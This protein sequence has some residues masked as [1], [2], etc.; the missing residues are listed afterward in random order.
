MNP[1]EIDV[2]SRRNVI[3]KIGA[4]LRSAGWVIQSA[5]NTDF[6]SLLGIAVRSFPLSRGQGNVGYL[7]VV[8]R[9]AAGV[10]EVIDTFQRTEPGEKQAPHTLMDWEVLSEKVRQGLPFSLP[11]HMRPL[12]FFYQC[13]GIKISF[14]NGFDP[15]PCV[16]NLSAFHKPET[17]K[18][19]LEEGMIGS[20]PRDMAAASSVEYGRRGTTLQE[21]IWINM[22]PLTENGLRL[23]QV[24]TLRNIERSLR[25]NRLRTLVQMSSGSG[26]TRVSISLI[27]RLVRF[28][29]AKRALILVDSDVLA[30]QVFKRF[31][32]YISPDTGENFGDEF[33]IRFVQNGT[34]EPATRVCISTPRNLDT[35]LEEREEARSG[36]NNL[37]P[38]FQYHSELPIET[39]D[40]IVVDACSDISGSPCRNVIE[41][42]DAFIIGLCTTRRK[43][44][45]H[46]FNQNLVMEYC[47]ES[48]IRISFEALLDTIAEGKIKEDLLV[49]FAAR[50]SR[51]T[52]WLSEEDEAA[53]QDASVVSSGLEMIDRQ[54]PGLT[55]KELSRHLTEVLSSNQIEKEVRDLKDGQG[56][57]PAFP[58]GRKEKLQKATAPFQ[59]FRLREILLALNKK[60]C[61]ST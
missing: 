8:D 40:V 25:E 54:P 46:L 2:F 21:R 12:P 57:K 1:S 11:V 61:G 29:D 35:C 34:I 45:D 31:H 49:V 23:H 55:L 15:S 10:I 5:D 37:E 41:Y 56:F 44:I 18:G 7:L 24:Q 14:R 39:F 59:S 17:L 30:V 13:S 27:Y 22:P 60:M 48:A 47:S 26:K 58:S 20:L 6:T 50:L 53:I 19:W 38:R 51:M 43:R 4:F 36:K 32:Q 9:K 3:Q 33:Q 28:A 52:Y 42:F 16:R